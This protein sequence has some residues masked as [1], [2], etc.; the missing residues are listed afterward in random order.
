MTLDILTTPTAHPQV[1]IWRSV[2]KL[3]RLRWILFI[4][5]FLRARRRRK[6]WMIVILILIS[7]WA[8]RNSRPQYRRAQAPPLA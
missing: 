6:I 1:S 7:G 8:G 4:T 5:G 3:F 2:W